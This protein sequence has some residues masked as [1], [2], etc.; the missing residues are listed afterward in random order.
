MKRLFAKCKCSHL[1]AV[2]H[3]IYKQ[4]SKPQI[5]AH[6]TVNKKAAALHI[7]LVRESATESPSLAVINLRFSHI[8]NHLC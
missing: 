8:H 6:L 3:L 7:I 5:A 2:L 1:N 4:V